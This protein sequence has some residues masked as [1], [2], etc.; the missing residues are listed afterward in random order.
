MSEEAYTPGHTHNATEFMARRT[1][2]SHGSFFLPFLSPGLSVLDC[3]CGP[4]SITL[5]IAQCVAPAPVIGIDMGASQ[6][7]EATRASQQAARPNARFETA[8]C[9]NVPLANCSVD[10]VFSHALIEHLA[11]P[12]RALRECFRVLKPGGCVGV[13]SPDWGGFILTPPSVELHDAVRAYTALQARNGGDVEAGRKLGLHLAA[14]GF[15]EIG[16]SARYE[17]YEAPEWIAQY[18]ALQL[19]RSGD[20]ISAQTWRDWH[21]EPGAMFA[22]AWVAAVAKKPA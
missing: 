16:L 7:E 12:V 11:D 4:G 15:G 1:L 18:L 10:R 14:A 19:E 13:C 5:G 3:G 21:R 22:Q 9:Y 6:I 8:S 20:T 2:Q 17:C